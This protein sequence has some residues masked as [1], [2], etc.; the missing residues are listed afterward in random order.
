MGGGGWATDRLGWRL[1]RF[2]LIIVQNLQSFPLLA[3]AASLSTYVYR[4]FS[5][6]IMLRRKIRLVAAFGLC[7]GMHFWCQKAHPPTVF[8]FLKTKT[9]FLLGFMLNASTLLELPGLL[10]LFRMVSI[11]QVLRNHCEHR[12]ECSHQCTYIF[13]PSSKIFQNHADF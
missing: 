11:L 9:T 3:M 4:C 8:R 12:L 7:S 2:E 1:S 5:N 6:I 13:L 10:A